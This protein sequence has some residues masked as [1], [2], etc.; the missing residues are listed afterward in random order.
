MAESRSTIVDSAAGKAALSVFL[1][2][3]AHSSKISTLKATIGN[4]HF[5]SSI[6]LFPGSRRWVRTA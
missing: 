5:I 4:F 2:Q 1:L 3:I 6:N